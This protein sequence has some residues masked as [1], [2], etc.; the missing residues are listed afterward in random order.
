VIV[1]KQNLTLILH[2]SP[3]P[4]GSHLGLT[5]ILTNLQYVIL[6]NSD[7]EGLK[8]TQTDASFLRNMLYFNNVENLIRMIDAFGY[9]P[10]VRGGVTPGQFTS[11]KSIQDLFQS[12]SMTHEL[13]GAARQ[14]IE[15]AT[16]QGLGDLKSR[17]K[18]Q[19]SFLL[20]AKGWNF[21]VGKNAS[22]VDSGG[23]NLLLEM[24]RIYVIDLARKIF[25]QER[26]G[27]LDRDGSIEYGTWLWGRNKFGSRNNKGNKRKTLVYSKE[28]DDDDI[29]D[30]EPVP[31]ALNSPRL[32]NTDALLR[33]AESIFIPVANNSEENCSK[34]SSLG[35]EITVFPEDVVA[36][37]GTS[38][39]KMHQRKRTKA[40]SEDDTASPGHRPRK[41]MRVVVTPN[42]TGEKSGQDN[43]AGNDMNR[44]SAV[45]TESSGGAP[46][47]MSDG[48][49]PDDRDTSTIATGQTS[50]SSV[51]DEYKAG[52]GEGT[53]SGIHQ[54]ILIL[55][56]HIEEDPKYE[57]LRSIFLNAENAGEGEDSGEIDDDME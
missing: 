51:I 10:R 44:E 47:E 36:D 8:T 37:S 11:I 42:A 54:S 1:Y 6:K 50:I 9:S 5:L 4:K 56:Q 45:N 38:R 53:K 26:N 55:L 33:I 32:L 25:L 20:Q 35:L 31:I 16:Y 19:D 23:G 28:N 7:P 21:L 24:I 27:K 46:A 41:Q 13:Y 17:R 29:F 12:P 3:T 2:H 34:K 14:D 52:L 15:Q 22:L 43:K 48:G 18:F 57:E 39:K 49:P 30:E 40:R